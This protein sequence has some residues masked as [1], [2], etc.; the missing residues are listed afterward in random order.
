MDARRR[1]RRTAPSRAI[2]K[3]TRGPAIIIALTLAAMLT[4]VNAASRSPATKPNSRSATVS[5]RR[6]AGTAASSATGSA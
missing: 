5:I 3:Y 2:A 6:A 4:I 1:A